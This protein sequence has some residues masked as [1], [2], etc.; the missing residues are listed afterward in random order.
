MTILYIQN[1]KSIEK[2]EISFDW[3]KIQHSKNICGTQSKAPAR[4]ILGMLRAWRNSFCVL[5]ENGPIT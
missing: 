1:N 4:N 2:I 3:L 5:D